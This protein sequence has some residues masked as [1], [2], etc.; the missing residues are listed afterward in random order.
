MKCVCGT[1][2]V[3]YWIDDATWAVAAPAATAPGGHLCLECAGKAIGRPLTLRDLA[4]R[5]YGEMAYSHPPAFVRDF[6][7]ATIAGACGPAR[8]AAP[9]HWE[10][11]PSERHRQAYAA[12]G[13]LGAELGIATRSPAATVRSLIAAGDRH[14]PG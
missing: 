5:R 10:H 6:L 7:R 2:A 9:D 11:V 4:V 3:P 1:A 13:D 14:F 8:V 12:A